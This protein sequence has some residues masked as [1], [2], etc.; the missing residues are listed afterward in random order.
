MSQLN[1]LKNWEAND[2]DQLLRLLVG[3]HYG[4][5]PLE[6][7][8][9]IIQ[10]KRYEAQNIIKYLKLSDKDC[11]MD[12]GSGCGFIADQIATTVDWVHCVDISQSFLEY[13]KK[14]NQ[15]HNNV[16]FCHVPYGQLDVNKDFSAI[17]SVSVFI[18]FNLYD[19]YWHLLQCYKCL[20]PNG[21]LLFDI[22]NFQK[23]DIRSELWQRHSA[24]YLKDRNSLFHSVYYNNKD[25]IK[26]LAEQ[27]GF[28]VSQ[29]FDEN[30]HS[31]FVLTKAQ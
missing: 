20:R 17:Y 4:N 23:L 28:L 13:A 29:C 8:D 6:K 24:N 25:T 22:L 14:V 7:L 19:C 18:H 5:N 27:I 31:F 3:R 11:V 1:F 30:D 26:N 15:H 10:I 2:V 16:G 9:S 21:R 12:L